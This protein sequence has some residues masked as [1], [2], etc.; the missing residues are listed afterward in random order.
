MT[1]LVPSVD[2]SSALRLLPLLLSVIGG[3]VDVIGFLWHGVFVAHI[4]GNLIIV[5]ARVV[6]GTPVGVATILSVP[7][8]V[9]M[10]GVVNAAVV[11]LESAGVPSLRWL[12]AVQVVCLAGFFG[13][14][15]AAG[16]HGSPDSITAVIALMLG[17]GGLATQNALVQAS[18]RGTPSTAVMTTNLTRFMHDLSEILLGRDHRSAA[19]A[20]TRAARTWPAIAG[21][22]GGAAAGAALYAALGVR[23][24]TLPLGLAL[25][26]LGLPGRPPADR[27]RG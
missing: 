6:A 26:A 13:L 5:A 22:A 24:L 18:I 2:D 20:R 19:A 12:L 7:L 16:T 10:L 25:V 17:V 27:S 8:F 23:S 1:T 4:T 21:F 3:S 14:A 15:V 11:R 9:V